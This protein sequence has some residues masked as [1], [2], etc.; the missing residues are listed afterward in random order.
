MRA[1]FICIIIHR[2]SLTCKVCTNDPA[3]PVHN[4]LD[5]FFA[6]HYLKWNLL[7]K[8]RVGSNLFL[9]LSFLKMLMFLITYLDA[10]YLI[11]LLFYVSS[12]YSEHNCLGLTNQDTFACVVVVL[13]ELDHNIWPVPLYLGHATEKKMYFLA[14]CLLISETMTK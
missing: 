4:A 14:N 11:R 5:I 9:L 12:F 1:H 13:Y 3:G 7:Q 6:D 2:T 8:Q 10:T